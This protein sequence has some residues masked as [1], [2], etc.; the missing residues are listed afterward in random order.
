MLC[1]HDLQM[2]DDYVR[3]NPEHGSAKDVWEKV[4]R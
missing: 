2:I 4:A 3:M 1:S